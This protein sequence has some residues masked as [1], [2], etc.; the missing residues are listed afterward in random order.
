M[1]AGPMAVAA[2]A[3]ADTPTGPRGA[4]VSTHPG[5]LGLPCWYITKPGSPDRPSPARCRNRR[6]I[7]SSR[8]RLRAAS[9]LVRL[10]GCAISQ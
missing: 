10:I 9:T 8:V 2:A 5:T 4:V 6:V 3:A 1:A 7:D